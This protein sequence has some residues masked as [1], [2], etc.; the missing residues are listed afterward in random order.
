MRRVRPSTACLAG[1]EVVEKEFDRNSAAWYSC[2]LTLENLAQ[3]V[4]TLAST[5][6]PCEVGRWTQAVRNILPVL[7]G[8]IFENFTISKSGQSHPR[9]TGDH[10]ESDM[11][12]ACSGFLK[13]ACVARSLDNDPPLAPVSDPL[14]T[15]FISFG[16]GCVLN[17]TE[18]TRCT[19]P[20][21]T[22]LDVTLP[23][24]ATVF[25]A[26]R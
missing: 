4:V 7:P 20:H 18:R 13:R 5:L 22:F 8:P 17:G 6:R 24:D 26:C 10:N 23:M 12:E 9:V 11:A 14:K 3:T 1:Y 15:Y 19:L 16:N 2:G 21:D 25:W